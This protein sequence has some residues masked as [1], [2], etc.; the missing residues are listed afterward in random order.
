MIRF[1][2][3]TLPKSPN[4]YLVAP[5]GLCRNA[6]P[7]ATAPVLACPPAGARD[8]FFQVL[9]CEP[10]ITPGAKDDATLQYEWVQRTAL[11]RFPDT[12][13]VRFIAASAATSTLA[14]Y[15]RSKYGYR[16]FGVNQA[17]VTDWLAK[18]QATL[19]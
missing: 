11:M 17:R 12:I 1:E 13:T 2:E 14:I 18:L 9:A 19:R 3:L 8:A 6:T 4:A 10:R 5:V 7:H 16:D 15:S